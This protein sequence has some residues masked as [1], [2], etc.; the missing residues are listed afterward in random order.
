MSHSSTCPTMCPHAP[1]PNPHPP[2]T[3]TN[4]ERL[5]AVLNTQG[6]PPL[7][8][9]HTVKQQT[10]SVTSKLY[11]MPSPPRSCR[12]I[13]S[14]CAQPWSSAVC[15]TVIYR[16]PCCGTAIDHASGGG[17][18]EV[19]WEHGTQEPAEKPTYDE[20]LC[21]KQQ[22]PVVTLSEQLFHAPLMQLHYARLRFVCHYVLLT[23]GFSHT[24]K[25]LYAYKIKYCKMMF[26]SDGHE[27]IFFPVYSENIVYF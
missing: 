26:V 24:V 4:W 19:E 20:V 6:P 21:N 5:V 18:G 11:C 9:Y 27:F 15:I 3:H 16:F 10:P 1:S 8:R 25:I 17:P 7:Q 23:R 2:T 13:S 22:H 12:F 14:P